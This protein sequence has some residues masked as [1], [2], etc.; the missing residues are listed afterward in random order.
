MEARTCG[1]CFDCSVAEPLVWFGSVGRVALHS[2]H[3]LWSFEHNCL[4]GAL[5]AIPTRPLASPLLLYSG[6]Q[7]TEADQ[8]RCDGE[9]RF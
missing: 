9:R 1:T 5:I 8:I 4:S 3:V 7:I 2:S 6:V